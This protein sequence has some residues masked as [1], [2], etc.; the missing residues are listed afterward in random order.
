MLRMDD[1]SEIIHRKCICG[2]KKSNTKMTVN[3]VQLIIINKS[4]ALRKKYNLME[5]PLSLNQYIFPS[6]ILVFFTHSSGL[7]WT[8]IIFLNLKAFPLTE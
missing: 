3:D 8:P 4:P 1:I 7:F 2:V 6:A 5:K